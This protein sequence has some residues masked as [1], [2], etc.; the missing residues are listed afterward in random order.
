MPR[1][2]KGDR[3][4]LTLRLPRPLVARV[5]ACARIPK[6]ADRNDRI[7]ALLEVALDALESTA[8]VPPWPAV[9][10]KH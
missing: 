2:H 8:A 1:Q 3:A 7:E 5:D 4:R 9:G 6:G 10:G